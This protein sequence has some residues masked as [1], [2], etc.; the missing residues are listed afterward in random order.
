MSDVELGK[1]ITTPQERD[2]IHVACVPLIAG[3]DLYA[4]QRFRLRYGHND[5]A[6]CADYNDD[7]AIG[8]IDPFLGNNDRIREGDEVWG[9]LFPNTVTGMRH[10]WQ[11]PA[12]EN[13]EK[14]DND[15]EL[16]IR[17]FCERWHFSFNELIDAAISP[18][19]NEDWRYVVAH[20]IDLHSPGELGADHDLFWHHL[21]GY[22]GQIVE[23]VEG[24]AGL[25]VVK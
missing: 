4:G 12:F 10:E 17:N 23:I 18:S 6:M 13:V 8:I 21:E 3:E 19:R 7:D 22:T 9:L 11:H 20:G 16:W 5:V 2:A 1:M 24:W 15:H 25:V 14:T